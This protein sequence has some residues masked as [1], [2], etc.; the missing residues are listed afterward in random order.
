MF[1]KVLLSFI[2]F[3]FFSYPFK[4][5]SQYNPDSLLNVLENSKEKAAILNLL[6]EAT[7]EDSLDLSL[8]YA[9]QALAAAKMKTIL[10]KKDL[11]FLALPKYSPISLNLIRPRFTMKKH[12]LS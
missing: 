2:I 4:G 6:A 11:P 7:L 9:D 12:S 8:Q 3:I 5:F 1:G 10:G